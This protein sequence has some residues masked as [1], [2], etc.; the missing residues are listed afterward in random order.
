MKTIILASQMTGCFPTITET[1]RARAAGNRLLF[2]PTAAY[3]EGWEPVYETD[4]APFEAA[5]F[6]VELFDLAGKTRQETLS[7]L[8][9]S[10]VVFISGGNTF[11]LLHHMK[12]SGFFDEIG[13]RVDKGLVYVGSSAGSVSA[14]PD[15]AYAAS[16][17]D[18][19]KGGA[20]GTMG[21]GFIDRPVL[22]HMDHPA[23]SQYVQAIA[24]EF[25]AAGIAYYGLN[26]DEAILV[27]EDGPK[28]VR[29]SDYRVPEQALPSKTI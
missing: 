27:D 28:V 14:T 7:A 25:D 24:D 5:G 3:G 8:D 1:A 20:L 22:P 21:L 9:R 26:D 19:S 12:A 17:D 13:A 2:V 4:I 11:H 18:P 10:D 23:F 15:I 6:A 29:A 16:V